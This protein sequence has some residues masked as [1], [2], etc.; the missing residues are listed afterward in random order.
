M[1]TGMGIELESGSTLTTLTCPPHTLLY[2]SFEYPKASLR[3]PPP[4]ARGRSQSPQP[5][6]L[7]V[8]AQPSAASENAPP[9]TAPTEGRTPARAAPKPRRALQIPPPS[10]PP[11]MN[12][13]L[14]S[15]DV[16]SGCSYWTIK[17]SV[18][19]HWVKVVD[20][21]TMKRIPN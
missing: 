11:E 21:G 7:S 20:S 10:P 6:S 17:W 8:Q 2:V 1:N 16:P 18:A 19:V 13:T 3:F 15:Y 9:A 12:V 5:P 14:I 4:V